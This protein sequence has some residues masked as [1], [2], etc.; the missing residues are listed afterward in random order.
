MFRKNKQS[1]VYAIAPTLLQFSGN[2][3]AAEEKSRAYS[4]EA[5]RISESDELT[6]R[7]VPV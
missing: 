1:L 7:P 5:K 2:S 3:S 6:Q 4:E